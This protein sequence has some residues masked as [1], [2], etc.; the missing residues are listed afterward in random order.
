MNFVM[1]I[2]N[3]STTT[4]ARHGT[5]PRSRKTAAV[6]A[7]LGAA[8]SVV[9]TGTL[10]L[11]GCTMSQ[12]PG[13]EASS[14][15]TFQHI[16]KLEAGRPDGSLLVA[17]HDGLYRITLGSDGGA[18]VSGPIGGVDFDLMGFTIA[19]GEFFASGHPGPKTAGTFGTPNLGLITS[20]DL[21]KTWVNVS[22]TGVTDFHALTASAMGSADTRVFGIDTSK[23]RIQ[24]SLDGGTTWSE[25]AE[26]VARD[27]LA[28]GEELYVTTPDGLVVSKDNGSSFTVDS[29]APALF[30]VAADQTGQLAGVDVAGK[31]WVR[32]AAGAWVSGGTLTTTPEALA[33]DGTRIYIADEKGIS[34]S[35]DMGV[36]WTVLT[37]RT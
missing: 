5:A 15:V 34:F 3:T 7:A 29:S 10:L 11:S 35:E 19:G 17:A 2:H 24:R 26:I 21:G 4:N 20:T 37:L 1:K 16:H 28:V 32:D 33:T 23:Q 9:V 13:T 25:G 18:T 12:T 36:M 30:L 22:L 6:A 31:L 27:I 8:L 14:E